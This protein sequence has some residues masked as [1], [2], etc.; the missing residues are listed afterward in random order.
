M[1]WSCEVFKIGQRAAGQIKGNA[2]ITRPIHEYYWSFDI[3]HCIY[4]TA[5][6]RDS[7]LH[8]VSFHANEFSPIFSY[9]ATPYPSPNNN[10]YFTSTWP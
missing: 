10:N 7:E 8:G 9:S 1:L 4:F 3:Q 6:M 2:L 5:F